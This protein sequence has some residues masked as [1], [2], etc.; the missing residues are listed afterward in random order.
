MLLFAVRQRA[1][2]GLL[3]FELLLA[4][5]DRFLRHIWDFL[6]VQTLKT[7]ELP[8][9]RVN[10]SF[11]LPSLQLMRLGNYLGLPRG[12]MRRRLKRIDPRI[13]KLF[14]L[15]A[16]TVSTELLRGCRGGP[17]FAGYDGLLR[18]E[19]YKIWSGEL[20]EFNYRF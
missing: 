11:S 6:G 5:T 19:N 3:P 20:A 9:R 4:D 2:A 8:Q 18:D 1:R 7:D 16:P 15:R 13:P 12:V 17:V 10:P 14:R